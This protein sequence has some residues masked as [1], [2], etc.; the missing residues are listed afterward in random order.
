[1]N[2]SYLNHELVPIDSKKSTLSI[3]FKCIKCQKYL[4][5]PNGYTWGSIFITDDFNIFRPALLYCEEEII[6]KLLE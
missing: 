1:M 3:Y 5:F 4:S 6:K 2:M